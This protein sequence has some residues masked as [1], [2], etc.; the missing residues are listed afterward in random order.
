[1]ADMNDLQNWAK[2]KAG[3]GDDAAAVDPGADGAAD[4][5]PEEEAMPPKEALT[6]AATELKEASDALEKIVGQLDD[7]SEV[8]E[9]IDALKDANEKL[10]AAAEAIEED[11]GDENDDE[12]PQ[13]E[14]QPNE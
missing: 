14:E 2:G 3:G 13:G 10:T 11:E 6:F 4:G 8:Q 9:I 5:Q 7:G 12:Q 1:M